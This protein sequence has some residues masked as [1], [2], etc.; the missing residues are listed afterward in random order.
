MAPVGFFLVLYVKKGKRGG[1]RERELIIHIS[2]KLN[3]NNII[4]DILSF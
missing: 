3:N 4:N 2:F 1:T